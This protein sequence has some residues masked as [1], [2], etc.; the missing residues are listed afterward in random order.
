MG[1]AHPVSPSALK[2]AQDR[3]EELE[4][5]LSA[6]RKVVRLMMEYVPP[7]GR[8]EVVSAMTEA[9]LPARGAVGLLGVSESGYYA[10]RERDPSARSLRHAW[11][12]RIIVGIH[13]SSGS[14]YGYRRI[15]QELAD[16][17]G[18]AVSHG[19]VELLMARAGI[20]GRAGRTHAGLPLTATEAVDRHWVVDVRTQGTP[21]GARSV[22][23]VL[24]SSS[25]RPVGWST[26]P[27]ASASLVDH[28][29]DMAIA[30]EAAAT[31][32]SDTPAGPAG[33]CFTERARALR[34]G[35][36]AG[37]V[38][39]R[40]AHAVAEA[41]WDDMRRRLTR[42]DDENDP[43]TLEKNLETWTSHHPCPSPRS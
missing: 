39:D 28:A 29:L 12:T 33:C 43:E 20:R 19:T 3:V 4:G 27:A 38:A 23:V 13:V 18:I 37:P 35:P 14:T 11:L 1:S 32:A 21:V 24:D 22:A 7:K 31:P 15:R 2:R 34:Q 42:H 30:H 6:Y 26:A 25:H 41:F 16:R 36:A 8:Y 9:G 10:W 5:E 40:F 17:Y